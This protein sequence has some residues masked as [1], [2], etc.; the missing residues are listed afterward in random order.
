MKRKYADDKEQNDCIITMI[1][2]S[3]SVWFSL[4]TFSAATYLGGRRVSTA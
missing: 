3:E 4:D 2:G 1:D